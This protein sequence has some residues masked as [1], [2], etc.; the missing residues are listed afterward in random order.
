MELSSSQ[1]AQSHIL[2]ELLGDDV[3]QKILLIVMQNDVC[4]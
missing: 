4:T 2:I 3:S 1:K